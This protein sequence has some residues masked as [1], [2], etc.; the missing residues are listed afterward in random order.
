MGI[1]A[2]VSGSLVEKEEEVGAGETVVVV[3]V[4]VVVTGRSR[5]DKHTI[6]NL[7]L[8]YILISIMVFD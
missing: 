3:V 2:T 6:E 1:S 5:S 4:V 7:T 8:N